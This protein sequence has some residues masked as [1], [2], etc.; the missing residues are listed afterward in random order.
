MAVP[1]H[2]ARV[3]LLPV[4]TAG[5]VVNKNQATIGQMCHASSE[6]RVLADAAIPSTAGSPTP[7]LYLEREAALGYIAYHIDQTTIVTYLIT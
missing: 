6:H 7:K 4:D 1:I 5:N 3:G 2:V